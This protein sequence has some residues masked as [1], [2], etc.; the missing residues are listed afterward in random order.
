MR[1]YKLLICDDEVLICELLTRLLDWKAQ[2]IELIG[3]A[4][5][6][7]TAL[8]IIEQECPDIVIAD[9]RMP[10]KDG[11]QLAKDIFEAG[12]KAKIIIISGYRNFE[13]AHKAIKYNVADYLIKPVREADLQNIIF[14]ITKELDASTSS[15]ESSDIQSSSLVDMRQRFMKELVESPQNTA[16]SDSFQEAF[17]FIPGYFQAF[18]LHCDMADPSH[19][20]FLT[21]DEERK[22]YEKVSRLIHECL[23]PIS[24]EVECYI[25]GD[26]YCIINYPMNTKTSADIRQA[27]R[28]ILREAEM[29]FDPSLFSCSMGVGKVLLDAVSISDSIHNAERILR[30]RIVLNCNKPLYAAEYLLDSKNLES[31]L[32]REYL[33]AMR[34]SLELFDVA[35]FQ[36]QLHSLY[37]KTIESVQHQPTLLYDLMERILDLFEFVCIKSSHVYRLNSSFHDPIKKKISSLRINLTRICDHEIAWQIFFC[38][39]LEILT[40]CRDKVR[41]SPIEPIRVIQQFIAEHLSEDI[42]LEVLSEVV[43]LNPSYISSLFYKETGTHLVEYINNLRVEQAK[44]MLQNSMLSLDQIALQTGFSS[45]RYFSRIFKERVGISPIQFR[46]LN[47]NLMR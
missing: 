25:S 44:V 30:G 15:N 23:D 9:I 17:S 31:I 18:V 7:E 37:D 38:E 46:R 28:R 3:Q 22:I 42:T 8:K 36:N 24:Y 4:H 11:L 32:T 12:L 33:E 43:Y 5:D 27:L 6:G 10:K 26:L 41:N 39:L 40:F 1:T 20:W 2:G 45:A 19:K 29:F 35:N 21:N 16:P 13:Y 34:Q 14:K 47:S